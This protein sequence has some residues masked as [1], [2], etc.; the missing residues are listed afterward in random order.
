MIINNQTDYNNLQDRMNRETH[1]S[2]PIFSDTR[3]H[4]IIN[5]LLCI[6]YIFMDGSTYVLSVTHQDG[7]S[8]PPLTPLADTLT[9][10][11]LRGMMYVQQQNLLLFESFYTKYIHDTLRL[12]GNMKN[13]NMIIP[14]TLWDVILKKYGS[15]LLS[16]YMKPTPSLNTILSLTSVLRE[17]ETDGLAVNPQ[18]LEQ[19]YGPKVLPYIHEGKIYS[20][21]N[22]YTTTGR[23]SNRYG[24]IN[25]SALNKNDGSRE[26]FISRYENGILVQIDFEA[27]HL[28]LIA[29]ELGM[30][31]PSTS[32]H[33]ELAIKYFGTTDITDEMYTLSKQ[34]TFEIMYGSTHETFGVE[35]FERIH[36]FRNRYIGCDTVTLA[37]GLT[38]TVQDPSPS[39]LYNYYVQ[40]LEVIRTLPKLQ[41]ILEL[42][43]NANFHLILYTYDSILLD[44]KEFD[45]ESIRQ[46]VDIL[47]D[48]GKFPVR[49]YKGTNYNNLQEERL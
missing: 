18:L 16:G 33:R 8:F 19:Y 21:Y 31:L 36:H 45:V 20:Q 22:P 44:M 11:I 43:Q 15:Y 38:V 27:Y 1:L 3:K 29:D 7:L 2:L 48:G 28:R 35:L 4:P 46:I 5:Q 23:P 6:G 37:N 9:E 34:K 49:V 42:R 14:L 24:G 10:D 26:A 40:S 12:F 17:I 25:F 47:E 39:K 13:A 30:S 41:K 32:I